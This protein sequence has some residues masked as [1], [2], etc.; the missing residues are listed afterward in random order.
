MFFYYVPLIEFEEEPRIRP[1]TE[2]ENEDVYSLA[3]L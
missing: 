2:V 1:G 3:G